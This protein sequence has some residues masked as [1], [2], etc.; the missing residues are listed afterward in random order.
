MNPWDRPSVLLNHIPSFRFGLPN[1][2]KNMIGVMQVISEIADTKVV[3]ITY[4]TFALMSADQHYIKRD[5]DGIEGIAFDYWINRLGTSQPI[6][7]GINNPNSGLKTQS[8]Y[9]DYNF[10]GGEYLRSISRTRTNDVMDLAR[11]LFGIVNYENNNMNYANESNHTSID[12]E[13][14]ILNRTYY[15]MEY[16]PY[17]VVY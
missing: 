10:R 13:L 9:G 4:D 6:G 15:G 8:I 7:T 14:N 16:A 12:S 1:S 5:D 11:G 17:C 3:D 2:F